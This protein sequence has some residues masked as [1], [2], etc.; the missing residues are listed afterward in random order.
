M[1][2][3]IKPLTLEDVEIAL[4]KD[5]QRL[6]DAIESFR[7]GKT[8]EAHLKAAMKESDRLFAEVKK[9]MTDAKRRRGKG[10]K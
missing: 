3:T 8:T 5:R 2:K 9:L 6:A 4:E 10:R 7:K 1:V